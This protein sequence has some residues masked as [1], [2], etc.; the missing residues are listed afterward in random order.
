MSFQTFLLSVSLSLG[1]YI[2]THFLIPDSS[3]KMT[4]KNQDVKGK[5]TIKEQS[6]I[7]SFIESNLNK[8]IPHLTGAQHSHRMETRLTVDRLK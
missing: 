1:F 5:E 6:S 7:L 4:M 8:R 3:S 2:K